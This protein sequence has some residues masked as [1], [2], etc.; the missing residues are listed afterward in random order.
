MIEKVLSK[1]NELNCN[2]KEIEHAPVYTIE[3]IDALGKEFFEGAMICKNLFV[4]DQKGKRHFLV[5]LPEEK[6]APLDV[7]ANKIGSTRLSFASPERLMKYLKLTP[8]SV[9]P[10]AVIND[11]ESA[12]EV[13]LEEDLKNQVKVGVHPC[14][15]TATI[16]LSMSDVE[17]YISSCGNKIKYIKI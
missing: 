2:Y 12:V 7:I 4:R 14:T 5:V 3:E 16:L 17:K 10:L 6:R 9:S 1:L 15:N 8:G 13:V 11:E